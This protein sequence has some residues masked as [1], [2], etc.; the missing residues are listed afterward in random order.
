MLRFYAKE[1]RL[2]FAK[3]DVNK[4]EILKAVLKKSKQYFEQFSQS[5]ESEAADRLF[6]NIPETHDS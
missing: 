2:L 4:T 6:E 5:E 1:S 3:E